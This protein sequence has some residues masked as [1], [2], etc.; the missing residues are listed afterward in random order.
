MSNPVLTDVGYKYRRPHADATPYLQEVR[1]YFSKRG[2]QVGEKQVNVW[3]TRFADQKARVQK[4]KTAR[5][6]AN[7]DY[8]KS[9][10]E[11]FTATQQRGGGFFD[12]AVGKFVKAAVAINP[13]TA[14]PAFAA[15]K[16]SKG[17]NFTNLGIGS[18]YDKTYDQLK[19]IQK[20]PGSILKLAAGGAALAA[21]DPSG[22]A[23]L[24][25]S[26][27]GGGGGGGGVYSSPQPQLIDPGIYDSG[28]GAPAPK[29]PLN[30]ILLIGGLAVA[31]FL[32][33]KL[34]K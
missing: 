32:A 15:D 10:A 20:N 8:K 13:Y 27:L 25:S 3:A 26:L 16:A 28:Y 9:F 5:G 11:Y 33:Y 17:S 23:G 29:N 22:I 31:G 21:G 19:S 30:T 2:K 24:L 34:L 18:V 12:T 7:T 14:G 4:I 6:A 1:D